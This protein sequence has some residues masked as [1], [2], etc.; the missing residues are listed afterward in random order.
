MMIDIAG[1][2]AELGLTLL[3]P[4]SPRGAYNKCGAIKIHP[5]YGGICAMSALYRKQT[6]A[7]DR[8]DDGALKQKGGRS[9]PF[10]RSLDVAYMP[11]RL[12][13]TTA[14]W[15]TSAT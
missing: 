11:F 12:N 5:L 3:P 2:L 7:D 13:T 10:S 14:F 1:S 4:P 15:P 9:R 6:S 8:A